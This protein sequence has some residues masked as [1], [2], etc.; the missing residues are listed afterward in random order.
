MRTIPFLMSE[1]SF[2]EPSFSIFTLNISLV[3]EELLTFKIGALTWG[4]TSIQL[5]VTAVIVF[6]ATV[7]DRKQVLDFG[8]A[9]LS[10]KTIFILQGSILAFKFVGLKV[11]EV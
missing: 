11:I 10:V 8:D 7:T 3:Y 6:T 1:M 4:V 2:E 9:F 5:L